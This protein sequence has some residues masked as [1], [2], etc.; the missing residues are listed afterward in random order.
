MVLWLKDIE[1][2]EPGPCDEQVCF[3]FFMLDVVLLVYILYK[4]YFSNLN[5]K[6]GIIFQLY[7]Q[8]SEI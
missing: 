8:G 3:S 7:L 2:D 1:G 4:K 5:R 6:V